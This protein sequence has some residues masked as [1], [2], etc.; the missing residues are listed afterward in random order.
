MDS[1]EGAAAGVTAVEG[2]SPPA[3]PPNP[4]PDSV[5]IPKQQWE[6]FQRYEQQAKGSQAFYE[7]AKAA[8]FEKPE[9]F[10]QWSPVLGTLKQRGIAP[11]ALGRILNHRV[12][13][14]KSEAGGAAFDADKLKSE[15]FSDVDTRWATKEHQ[16]ATKND[17]SMVGRAV[18]KILGDSQ[19]SDYDKALLE[20][21]I[22]RY[23]DTN[24]G[25]YPADHPLHDR[26]LAPLG[27]KDVEE[28]V[29]HFTG[30]RTKSMGEQMNKKAEA[31][32]NRGSGK[33]STPAG[34]SA[35][36]GRPDT[37]KLV[38]MDAVNA[39]LRKSTEKLKSA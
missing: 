39:A 21:A 25:V 17:P 31:A 14:D 5:T 15:I 19:A 16:A 6:Q 30:L 18:E 2:V 32:A 27:D 1:N 13:E 22:G 20:G 23:M 24:R 8:G 3:A 34:A 12:E 26:T 28:A 37:D 36:S 38:G 35:Q 10:D 7:K 11:D 9:H 4:N 33:F 29:K